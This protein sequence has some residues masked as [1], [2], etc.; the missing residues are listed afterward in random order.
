MVF[1]VL[2]STQKIIVSPS[3]SISVVNAGPVGPSGIQGDPGNSGVQGEQG[4]QGVIGPQG[5]QGIP[6]S[7]INSTT[8]FPI[9]IPLDEWILVH[10]YGYHPQIH[11][12]DSTGRSVHGAVD[13]PDN[14]T[15][16]LLNCCC[17]ILERL[18]LLHWKF[19]S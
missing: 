3:S 4:V 8:P 11:I 19:M 14:N 17:G 9:L 5:V 12:E 15:V 2:S 16:L 13:Y 1:V 7:G 6:G 10:N 18:Q